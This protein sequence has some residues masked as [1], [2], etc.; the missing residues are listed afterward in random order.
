MD[1]YGWL[2]SN[3]V[4]VYPVTNLN[5]DPAIFHAYKKYASYLRKLFWGGGW[6]QNNFFK[7]N[8]QFLT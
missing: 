8:F 2:W 6:F 3:L 1:V 4:F 5:V 7:N